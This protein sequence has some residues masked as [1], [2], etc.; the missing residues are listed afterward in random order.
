[1]PRPASPAL[2]CRRLAALLAAAVA[3][4]TAQ[5]GA[6]QTAAPA[7]ADPAQQ[8]E[9]VTEAQV[10][11]LRADGLIARQAEIS[12]GLLLMDRQLRQAQLAQ[13]LVSLFGPETPIEI[14]PGQFRDFSSTPLG[15]REQISRLQLE[16][17]LLELNG[18]VQRARQ[19]A[20]GSSGFLS[21]IMARPLPPAP[22]PVPTVPTTADSDAGTSPDMPAAPEA[23][24]VRVA[25]QSFPLEVRGLHGFGGRYSALLRID[26][27]DLLVSA[28]DRLENGVA[29]ISIDARQVVLDLPGSGLRSFATP[30]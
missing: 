4:C 16:L 24:A 28:G 9:P 15:L 1:M 11:E 25:A 6:A 18:E 13:Q 26:G 5:P 20:R 7:P 10:R 12:E 21:G 8:V 17:E 3:L 19:E 14:A 27:E 2:P 29:V 30:D 23:P 22:S